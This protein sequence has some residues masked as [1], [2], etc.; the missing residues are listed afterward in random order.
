L[1]YID[2]FGLAEGKDARV[3]TIQREQYGA[4]FHLFIGTGHNPEK[5]TFMPLAFT[6]DHSTNYHGL[7]GLFPL[8][9]RC[10]P[11]SSSPYQAEA[12]W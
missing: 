6:H 3:I 10:R 1:Y 8:L 7:S 11:W 4:T 2:T 9:S 5:I 12:F